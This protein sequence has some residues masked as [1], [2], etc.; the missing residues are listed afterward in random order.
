[1]ALPRSARRPRPLAIV[2]LLALLL[3]ILDP[4]EGSILILAGSAVVAVA[5]LVGRSRRTRLASAA[6]L[7]VLA[8][9]GALWGTSALGGI[10]G[11][12]GRSLWWGLLFLPYPVGWILALVGAI[13]LIR[14]ASPP[15]L[16]PAP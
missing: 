7:L 5:A 4:L 3:G 11:Q 14:E 6:F 16:Q 13:R 9:V 1:V 10:G 15:A 2:G 8:G 12:T